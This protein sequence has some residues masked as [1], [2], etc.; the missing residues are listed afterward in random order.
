MDEDKFEGEVNYLSIKDNTEIVPSLLQVAENI[1]MGSEVSSELLTIEQS[2]L[3][4][5]HMLLSIYKK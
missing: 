3:K 4:I 2:R 5:M 1:I